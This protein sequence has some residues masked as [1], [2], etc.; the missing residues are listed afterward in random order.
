MNDLGLLSTLA[1][2]EA[3]LAEL[4]HGKSLLFRGVQD[5]RYQLV[6]SIGRRTLIGDSSPTRVEKRILRL[7]KESALPHLGFTPRTDWEWLA[8]AQHHGLPTRLLDWTTNPL[9]AIYFATEFP[10]EGSSRIFVYSGRETVDQDAR[11]DPF[12]VRSVLRFR[13]PHLDSRVIAQG[14]TFT[15]HPSPRSPFDS[16]DVSY[17][18]IPLA[19]RRDLRRK[20]FK[21]GV[22][23]KTLF[24]GLDGLAQDLDWLH[25][26]RH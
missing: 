10:H 26:D 6:P 19:S 24:P 9:V 13:P 17:V 22:S 14:S 3:L 20:L 11:P 2:L 25:T 8:V 12:S 16:K 23:R 1:D 5:S 4:G 18:D 7:F 21:I 15:I